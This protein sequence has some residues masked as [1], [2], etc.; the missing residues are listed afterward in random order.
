[1]FFQMALNHKPELAFD[2]STEDD[3]R[4]WKKEA[5]PRV[6]ATLGD[7]PKRV[8]LNPQLLA[9]WEHDDL[10]KQ[11]WVID[12]GEYIS[13]ALV[14]AMPKGLR[15]GEKRPG[16]LC[17]HGHGRYGK[18]P[19]MGNDTSPGMLEDIQRM[20]YNYGHQMAKAGFVTFGIDW[21]GAGERNDDKWPNSISRDPEKDNWCDKY[22][23][24]ATMLGMTSLS[25]NITHGM[26]A[27]D[28]ACTLSQVDPERLGVM[29]LSGGG[30]MTLWSAYCDERLKAAEIICYSDVFPVFLIRDLNACGMQVA[31]G[32][33]KLAN[34]H[35]IQGLLA[36][37]PLL[38]DIGVYDTCFHVDTALEC[39]RNVE[40]IY[41][42]AGAS[43]RLELDYFPGEHQW[44]GNKSRE[45]FGK[46]LQASD[47][48]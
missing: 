3:F 6:L 45:F 39:Y 4:S 47:S 31:P 46:Y 38:I 29:G 42:A 23:L 34:L 25:I 40:R 21:I 36:P 33:F 13:A 20:N 41:K 19:V 24:N 11:R 12:V 28:F 16:I 2:G 5:Y 48:K 37:K 35:D 44:G 26:A 7:F 32:L 18:E 17:W 14:V 27:V 30:T 10:I 1:M 43:D 22:Y 15:A 8:P 9:E